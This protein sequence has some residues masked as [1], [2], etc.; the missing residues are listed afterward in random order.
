MILFVCFLICA[1]SVND[2]AFCMISCAP[3]VNGQGQR[4]KIA[5]KRFC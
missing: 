4:K 5:D 2:P 3:I 1:F